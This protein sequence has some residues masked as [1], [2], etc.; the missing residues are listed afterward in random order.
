MKENLNHTSYYSDHHAQLTSRWRSALEKG[1]FDAGIVL[2]GNED[3]YFQ[4]DQT[5]PFRPNPYLVQWLAPEYCSPGSLF[6]I[7]PGRSPVYYMKRSVDYWH[8]LSLIHI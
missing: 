7:R 1:G 5:Y 3:Y 2:A 4:D 8:A 6:V